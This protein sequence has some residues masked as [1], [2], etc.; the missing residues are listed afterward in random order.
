MKTIA[1][2]T[3]CFL[4]LSTIA[5]FPEFEFHKI[6]EYGSKMGQTSLIDLDEDGDLVV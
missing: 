3:I 2:L 4:T 6:G 5:Q 1:T